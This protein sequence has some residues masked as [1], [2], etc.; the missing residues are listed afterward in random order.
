MF[1][2]V[3]DCTSASRMTQC[4]ATVLGY[5]LEPPPEGFHIGNDYWRSIGVS[6]DELDQEGDGSDSLRDPTGRGPRIWFQEVPEPKVAK[7][8]IHLDLGVSGGR[9]VPLETCRA[10]HYAVAMRDPEGNEFDVN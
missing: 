5:E 6:E 4:W 7:N 2:L 9:D 10:D 8:R 1:Q 3:I